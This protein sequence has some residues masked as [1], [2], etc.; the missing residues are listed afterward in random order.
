[1]APAGPPAPNLPGHRRG[2]SESDTAQTRAQSPRPRSPL[3]THTLS[4]LLGHGVE[5]SFLRSS[6]GSDGQAD[7]PVR[8]GL[9]GSGRADWQLSLALTAATRVDATPRACRG[10]RPHCLRMGGCPPAQP[11]LQSAPRRLCVRLRPCSSQR[12]L[13]AP[14]TERHQPAGKQAVNGSQSQ[15]GKLPEEE[16]GPKSS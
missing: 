1:M 5:N 8:Q 10:A 11:A 13:W 2:P 4:L 16:R 12:Q 7:A 6:K 15:G 3:C 14:R 9:W